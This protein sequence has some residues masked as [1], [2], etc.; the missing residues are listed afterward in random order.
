MAGQS[1][2]PGKWPATFFA[3]KWFGPGI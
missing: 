3:D 1:I 2:L